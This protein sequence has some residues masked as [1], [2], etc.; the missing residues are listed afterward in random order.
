[1]R[2]RSLVSLSFCIDIRGLIIN[3]L[4][5]GLVVCFRKRGGGSVLWFSE[6]VLFQGSLMNLGVG[7]F[8]SDAFWL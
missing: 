3:G 8:D 2:S 7:F 1:M 5:F 4:S 6:R